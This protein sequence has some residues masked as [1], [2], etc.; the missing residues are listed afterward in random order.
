MEA[1]PPYMPPRKKS[2]TGLI[3]GLVIGGIVLCCI[4]PVVLFGGALWWGVNKALPIAGCG[5]A[6]Q[7]ARDAL[8]QYAAKHDGQLP[9]AEN[10]QE[11]V[12]P[13][14]E[15]I[16]APQLAERGPIKSMPSTGAWGC[17]DGSGGHT[18]MA[19]NDDVAGKKFDDVQKSD[20]VLLFEIAQASPSAHAKYVAQS[21][22]NS[23]KLFGQARGWFLIRGFGESVLRTH[24]REK[25]I[26]TGSGQVRIETG[27]KE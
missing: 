24:G 15:A 27:A 6:F 14:Y 12:A 20:E 16:V 19:Y 25:P 3:V 17:E 8:R 13:F 2:N 5:F 18:G 4:G 10:W 7:D 21:D 9:P 11:A 22:A 23:P 26:Q 1:P